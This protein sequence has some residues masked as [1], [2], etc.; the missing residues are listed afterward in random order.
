M[1]LWIRF[2][3]RTIKV[4]RKCQGILSYFFDFNELLAFFQVLLNLLLSHTKTRFLIFWYS[5]A[6]NIFNFHR[7]RNCRVH[8]VFYVYVSWYSSF[9]IKLFC[10]ASRRKESLSACVQ[11]WFVNVLCLTNQ[12]LFL[13]FNPFSSRFICWLGSFML[14]RVW[15]FWFIQHPFLFCLLDLSC[16]DNPSSHHKSFLFS[17]LIYF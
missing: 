11:K 12:L 6:F 16:S 8:S 3:I 1:N 4:R 9:Y 2:C 13:I 7:L 15:C 5:K 14:W 10:L 17:C